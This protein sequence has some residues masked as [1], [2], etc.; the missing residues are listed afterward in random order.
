MATETVQERTSKLAAGFYLP[1]LKKVRFDEKQGNKRII[2]LAGPT[3]VGKTQLSLLLAKTLDGEII[4]ADSMQVYRGMDIGTAKATLQERAMV[5]HHLIDICDISQ[6]FNVVDFFEE[7]DRC[8]DMILARG[9]VPI[10]VGGSGFYLHALLY[11][12]PLGPASNPDVRRQLECTL[13]R[14][15][16]DSLYE[17][18]E[19]EDRTYALSISRNDHHKIIRALEI[20]AL[21]GKKV[22]SLPWKLRRVREGYDFRPWFL[23]IPRDDLYQ[24][25]EIRCD[26]MLTAGLLDEV[27]ALDKQGL[28]QN[29]SAAQAI[30]YRQSLDFL[31]TSQSEAEYQR[32]V[33]RF[34]QA[35]RHYAKRQ[36]TWFRKEP[37]FEWLDIHNRDPKEII[38]IIAAETA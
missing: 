6:P 25:L 5:P 22:S 12:A 7:A 28:R 4:S 36:F 29:L 14:F 35:V 13:L 21:T 17:R 34:K 31:E 33:I 19:Q 1:Q 23:H 2:L 24:K 9:K 15:G 38:D 11:G 18:L 10:V 37:L 32:Y 30:G 8:C 3:G 27:R 26:Q 20:I 16:V